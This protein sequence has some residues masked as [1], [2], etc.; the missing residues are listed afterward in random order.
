MSGGGASPHEGGLVLLEGLR[1]VQLMQDCAQGMA[2][3]HSR[4][5]IHRD[6][7]AWCRALEPE[8]AHLGWPLPPP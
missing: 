4:G 3:L 2:F 5:I 1:M 8:K 7:S 6:L